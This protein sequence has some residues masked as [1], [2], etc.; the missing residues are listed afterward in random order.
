M[1][2]PVL[3][4]ALALMLL[5]A[6]AGCSGQ[7]ELACNRYN[8]MGCGSTCDCRVCGDLPASCNAYVDCVLWQDSCAGI[9]L[10]CRPPSDCGFFV[11]LS[12]R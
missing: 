2:R 5:G 3:L 10:N 7:C 9:A 11:A 12:C 4:L 1:V 8:N 6:T